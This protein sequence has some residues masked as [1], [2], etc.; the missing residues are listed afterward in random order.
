MD[1]FNIA[2]IAIGLAMDSFAVSVSSGIIIKRP[3]ILDSLQIALFFGFFQAFMPVLGWLAGF[4][5][6]VIISGIDHWVAFIILFIIGCRMIYESFKRESINSKINPLN[7][8]VLLMLSIATSI[9]ALIVGISFSFLNIYILTPI[10][11]IG[12]VAFLMSFIG[13]FIGNKSNHFLE[14]KIEILG[15]IILIGIG[16]KILFEHLF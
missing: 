2:F 1:L 12:V 9:D 13:V 8:Y 7:Y 3:R 6:K 4:S 5:L 11:A 16:L 10:F 14:K 15:G